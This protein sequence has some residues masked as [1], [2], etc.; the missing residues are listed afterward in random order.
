M[1]WLSHVTRAREEA[2]D[3]GVAVGHGS[4]GCAESLLCVIVT[5]VWHGLKSWDLCPGAM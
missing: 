5:S 1:V 2:G 3:G 4:L